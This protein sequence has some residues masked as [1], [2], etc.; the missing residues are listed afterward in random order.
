[1]AIKK[2]FQE[3][4]LQTRLEP[5]KPF[6]PID[7]ETEFERKRRET[8]DAAIEA[9]RNRDRERATERAAETRRKVAA[10]NRKDRERRQREEAAKKVTPQPFSPA[11]P[12][13]T[14]EQLVAA[15][16]TT[17]QAQEIHRRHSTIAPAPPDPAVRLAEKRRVAGATITT[18]VQKL[19]DHKVEGGFNLSSALASGIT[20]GQLLAVGFDPAAVQ[21]A[22]PV[23]AEAQAL[24]RAQQWRVA[25]DLVRREKA[26]ADLSD[27]KV[28]GGY[29]LGA[30]L[31]DG[32]TARQLRQAGFLTQD[33]RAAREWESAAAIAAAALRSL[34]DFR[35]GDGYDIVLAMQKGISQKHLLQAGFDP[36]V[37][38]AS[39]RVAQHTDVAQAT[40]MNLP[41]SVLVDAGFAKRDVD[42]LR[43]WYNALDD[44]SKQ[45]VQSG[46][47]PAL[48]A[49]QEARRLAFEAQHVKLSTNEWVPRDWFIALPEQTQK[50]L[51]R[52]GVAILD[53]E[54]LTPEKKLTRY[55]L[56]GLVP[57]DAVYAG[58]EKGEPLFR[59]TGRFTGPRPTATQLR[60]EGSEQTLSRGEKVYIWKGV[61]W[62]IPK[63]G[64]PRLFD[65]PTAGGPPN[66]VPFD[67]FL[68]LIP[69][70]G[71]IAYWNRMSPG[72]RA[73][74][75]ALDAL[76][77]LPLSRVAGAVRTTRAGV[78]V[79]VLGRAPGAARA[80]TILK[81]ADAAE[82]KAFQFLRETPNKVTQIIRE[83]VSPKLVPQ[84]TATVKAQD[85]YVEALARVL[86]I[87]K[88]P[89]SREAQ[90]IR[91]QGGPGVS[92]SPGGPA[93][94]LK[95]ELAVR[96]ERA[97]AE[98]E[99]ATV[100]YKRSLEAYKSKTLQTL[101]PFMDTPSLA[102][103]LPKEEIRSTTPLDEVPGEVFRNTTTIVEEVV[104]GKTRIGAAREAVARAQKRLAEAQAKAPADPS[105]WADL[106]ADL[107]RAEQRLA[108]M[109]TATLRSDVHRLA[110]VRETLK[111]IRRLKKQGKVDI[112]PRN[113]LREEA[114]LSG[115]VAADIKG[116]EL[117]WERGGWFGGGGRR[118]VQAPPTRPLIELSPQSLRRMG[119]KPSTVAGSGAAGSALRGGIAEIRVTDAIAAE[120]LKIQAK[121]V[122]LSSRLTPK[123]AVRIAT[124]A[125]ANAEKAAQLASKAKVQETIIR[126]AAT[127]VAAA[128]RAQ[129]AATLAKTNA[130]LGTRVQVQQAAKAAT[131]AQVAAETAVQTATS[132]APATSPA[133]AP[134][135]SPATAPAT[136]PAT[137]P[138]TSPAT[139]PATSP[140]TAPAMA[141]AMATPS[142]VK[143]TKLT[144]TAL[145]NRTARARR[146]RAVVP[147]LLP[148]GRPLGK[149]EYPRVIEFPMGV[150]YVQRDLFTGATTYRH[151]P[152]DPTQKPWAGL[153]VL[154][155][156]TRRPPKQRLDMGEVD[157]LI[158]GRRLRFVKSDD[159]GLRAFGLRERKLRRRRGALA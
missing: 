77:F 14:V 40:S 71:T 131:Q 93:R 39:A 37:V 47:A 34:E 3:D 46:G 155:T 11:I 140:A 153:V 80:R 100:T 133:T 98:L 70:V 89:S 48:E 143:I 28:D 119:L 128:A 137:A 90:R 69:V 99:Q 88:G 125:A 122:P 120:V 72:W 83:H 32:V 19:E 13:P 15:G 41:P 76:F 17:E 57:K 156:A 117:V 150:T 4:P 159:T 24:S 54:T 124:R 51:R 67:L 104:A 138:A 146:G 61:R 121:Q 141:P 142:K 81:A 26:L 152:G 110:E 7:Q 106:R 62:F 16:A 158:N 12:T 59:Q 149:R 31:A 147:L 30:A 84:Y 114:E 1:M 127:A 10:A 29:L 21:E 113:L 36:K 27:Y 130:I 25:R 65:D 74:S 38:Q 2:I 101:G 145:A 73:G 129:S 50:V 148:D 91:A 75:I 66:Q 139:A 20:K 111:D 64:P 134:A 107:A 58:E 53:V 60:S 82:R 56:L 43:T 97:Q 136:S 85:N 22:E 144:A 132:T 52:E 33:I 126:S 151:N 157:A 108:S 8:Q 35:V 44:D 118:A 78:A 135:T 68:G 49:F 154:K 123:E 23:S 105:K 9:E 45:A 103:R 109:K 102:K 6:E 87:R 79:E 5:D 86:D 42:V 92:I 96:L 18:V 112:I 115:K 55:R 94:T 63:S 116:L 95:E